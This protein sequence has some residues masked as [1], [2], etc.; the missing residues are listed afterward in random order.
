[1][2]YE[3]ILLSDALTAKGAKMTARGVGTASYTLDARGGGVDLTE[4]IKGE[5]RYLFFWLSVNEEHSAP[6]S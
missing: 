2:K 5:H 3:K 4:F 1:M 6:F